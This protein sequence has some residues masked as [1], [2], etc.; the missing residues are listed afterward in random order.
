MV[1]LLSRDAPTTPAAVRNMFAAA[2]D[3]FV[4]L[5]IAEKPKVAPTQT[6]VASVASRVLEEMVSEGEA[7]D[8]ALSLFAH[9]H[10]GNVLYRRVEVSPQDADMLVALRVVW[11]PQIRLVRKDRVLLR[12]GVSVGDNGVFLAQDVGGRSLR[13]SGPRRLVPLIE[14]LEAAIKPRSK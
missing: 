5:L 13:L 7:L 10:M 4:L 14:Q 8:T 9:E 2:G 1:H 3:R 6:G 12:S 11:I